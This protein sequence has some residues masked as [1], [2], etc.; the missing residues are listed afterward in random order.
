MIWTLLSWLSQHPAQ[1]MGLLLFLSAAT[2]II[3]AAV[4]GLMLASEVRKQDAQRKTLD[5]VMQANHPPAAPGFKRTRV[6]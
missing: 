6:S 3:S 4:W 5:R 1:V 2:W